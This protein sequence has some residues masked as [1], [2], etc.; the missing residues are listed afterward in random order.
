[1][2]LA[3]K[4]WQDLPNTTTPITATELNRL[5]QGVAS[6]SPLWTTA[7]AYKTGE[8]VLNGT[9]AYQ[10]VDDHTAG[11]TF[12]GDSAHWT[13]VSVA[14]ELAYAQ[15]TANF[16]H[17]GGSTPAAIT[18][19]T[20]NVAAQTL[21]YYVEMWAGAVDSDTIG[22]VG[23]ID[24]YDGTSVVVQAAWTNPMSGGQNLPMI[25]IGRVAAGAGA[26]TYT[27]RVSRIAGS[28]TP[29]VYGAA[30]YPAFLRARIT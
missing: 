21:A 1:M 25:V 26:K 20:I 8:L 30:A 23:I 17:T 6:R 16:T 27:A 12:S 22:D 14:S 24:I 11:A 13:A 19:L 9:I 4:T 2:V 5:E 10:A 7:T 15:S 3:R 18:G 29:H 28:G